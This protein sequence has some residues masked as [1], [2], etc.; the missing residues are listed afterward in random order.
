VSLSASLDRVLSQRYVAVRRLIDTER[1]LHMV[2]RKR[3]LKALEG[4]TLRHQV[5]T[6]IWD[7]NTRERVSLTPALFNSSTKASY[8]AI[9]N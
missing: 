8:M 1:A 9:G 2:R 6:G 4:P 3:I 5:R 7:A